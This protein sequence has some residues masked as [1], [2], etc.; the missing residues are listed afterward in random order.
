MGSDIL[1]DATSSRHAVRLGQ[2]ANHRGLPPWAGVTPKY[3]FDSLTGL[4]NAKGT[5]LRKF[6]AGVI[7][8]LQGTGKCNVLFLGDSSLIG[9][10]GNGSSIVQESIQIPRVFQDVLATILGTQAAGGFV[11]F[12]GASATP[13]DKFVLNSGTANSTTYPGIYFLNTASAATWSPD[14]LGTEVGFW[15]SDLSFSGFTYSIDGATAVPVTTTGTS[16]WK[17][18]SVTGLTYGTHTLKITN[19]G[20]A[21]T[22]VFLSGGIVTNSYG[23]AAHNIAWGGSRAAI[24]TAALNWTDVVS[25]NS[26]YINR[27]LMFDVTPAIVPDLVVVALGAND[28]SQGD[29][30]ANAVAG[31]NTIRGWYPSSDFLMIHETTLGGTN[32]TTYDDYSAQKYAL[33]DTLDCPLLDFR[34]KMGDNTEAIANGLIGADNA[35]MNSS[36]TIEIAKLLAGSLATF[37]GGPVDRADAPVVASFGFGGLLTVRDGTMRFVVPKGIYT[38]DSVRAVVGIANTGAA[39]VV[40]V[41]KWVAGTSATIFSGGTGR[42]SIPVSTANIPVLNSAPPST[43]TV[44]GGD[45]LSGK[46]ST[47]GS[48]LPGQDLTIEVELR[49]IA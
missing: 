40:D 26:L 16:A 7:R 5:N 44:Q 45:L 8:A 4:Y 49:R 12:T 18:L 36:Q 37:G 19:G 11:P 39:V 15:Y 33:A 41:L 24:G 47:I 1:L 32:L 35:H 14:R 48:T 43:L 31:L 34:H 22:F 17:K 9:Y 23:I 3:P 2:A 42:P 30:A 25:A 10:N 46:I 29:T 27:K 21:G 28:I 38:I 20:G 6:H 13:S